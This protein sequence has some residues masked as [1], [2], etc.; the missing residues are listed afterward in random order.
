MSVPGRPW[1]VS[2]STSTMTPSNP[3]TAH[4]HTLASMQRVYSTPMRKSTDF[5]PILPHG[6]VRLMERVLGPVHLVTVEPFTAEERHDFRIGK[7]W[8]RVNDISRLH[9]AKDQARRLEREIDFASHARPRYCILAA[10]P[11]QCSRA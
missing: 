4:E 9:L 1:V 11:L 7:G 10:H 5:H 8:Q 2:T 6:F 3:I